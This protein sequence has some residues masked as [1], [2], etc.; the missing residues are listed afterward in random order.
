MT[1]KT[2]SIIDNARERLLDFAV[3]ELRNIT[4]HRIALGEIDDPFATDDEDADP[5]SPVAVADY[6][7]MPVYVSRWVN[8]T[9][10][11]D[12]YD[13]QERIEEI[14]LYSEGVVCVKFEGVDEMYEDPTDLNDLSTDDMA[15]VVYALETIWGK[16]IK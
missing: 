15:K 11:D 13:V 14:R 4:E 6:D 2:Y 9:Y 8:D 3:Y 12:H 10:T 1:S 5:Y 7:V 16:L